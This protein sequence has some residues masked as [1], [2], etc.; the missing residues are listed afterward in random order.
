[1]DLSI[2]QQSL[3]MTC[4]GCK[5]EFLVLRGSVFDADEPAGL[6]LIA[7][8][9]HSPGGPVAHLAIALRNPGGEA[10]D[11]VAV[12]MDVVPASGDFGFIVVDWRDSTWQT[13][14]YLG[15]QIDRDE[16]IEHSRREEF[17]EAAGYVAKNLSE[18][19]EYLFPS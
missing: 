9:G 1:M 8:H 17:L 16:A 15:E 12:A 11:A 3:T 13:E 6:Y 18:V 19:S 4:P 5:E 7:L 2:D 14:S 10:S